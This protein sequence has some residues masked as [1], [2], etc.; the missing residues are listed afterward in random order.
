VTAMA[1]TH[2]ADQVTVYGLDLVG[3][4]LQSLGGLPH[5]GGVAVR[6]DAERIRR[7]SEEIRGM[8]EHRQEVFRDR[9]IDSVAQLRRMH[10]RGEVPELSCADV[11]LCIDV[12]GSIRHEFMLFYGIIHALMQHDFRSAL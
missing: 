1:L 3:G 12:F 11:V 7:T 5:V 9:T 8:L 4:G 10:A 2:T 6:T